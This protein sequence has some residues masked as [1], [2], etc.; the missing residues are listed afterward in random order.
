MLD[1]LERGGDERTQAAY[2][3]LL[4]EGSRISRE[5]VQ[6][7]I[8]ELLE[9]NTDASAAFRSLARSGFYRTPEEA[10]EAL[11]DIQRRKAR[12]TELEQTPLPEA[13]SA[14]QAAVDELRRTGQVTTK[15]GRELEAALNPHLFFQPI[16]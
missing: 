5:A 10:F 2:Q 6:E 13:R 4:A 1:A 16:Q 15:T 8:V 11:V 9:L 7:V 3:R 14:A 12:L